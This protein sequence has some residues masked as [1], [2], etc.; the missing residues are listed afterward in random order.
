[1]S[2]H[3]SGLFLLALL[4]FPFPVMSQPSLQA[5]V[6]ATPPGGT[7]HLSPGVYAGPVTLSRPIVLEGGGKAT[8]DGGGKRTVLWLNTGNAVVRGLLLRNTG[9]SHDQMDAGIAVQGD[10]NRIEANVIENA[11]FGI[12]LKQSKH[13]LVR[14]NRIRS[15]AAELPLRGEAIRLW[16]STGN[17]IEDNDIAAARDFTLMNSAYNRISGNSIQGSRYGMHFIFSPNCH[18]EGNR[19]SNNA[20]GIIVLNSNYLTIR[21][22]T[23][24]HTNDVSGACI[25]IKKSTEIQAEGNQIVHCATGILSDSPVGDANKVVFR[26]NLIAHNTTGVQMYGEK[27]GHTFENNRFEKNLVQVAISGSGDALSNRWQ[28]NYWDDYQGFDLNHD[29]I[30]DTPHEVYAYADRI[31]M[32]TPAAAFFRNSPALELLDFL[33]RLAPFSTPDL[34]LRDPQPRFR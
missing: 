6:D 1:M 26:R 14:N 25:A 10:S 34:L 17:R 7:L 22:N 28:G 15:K 12:V 18:V 19:L 13:N 31:W 33:E 23:L 11:L 5:L 4:G 9:D 24:Q 32:E 30:G 21:N 2:R 3:V 29:G 20:T 27:G 8:I 16:N